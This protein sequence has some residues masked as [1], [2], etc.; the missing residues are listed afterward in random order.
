MTQSQKYDLVVNSSVNIVVS[1]MEFLLIY[2]G[3]A[4]YKV[5]VNFLC[6]CVK[7]VTRANNICFQDGVKFALPSARFPFVCIAM[8]VYCR[9]ACEP[10]FTSK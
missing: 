8:R 9:V 5:I 1:V 3:F 6:T 4:L 2:T 10:F 7:S